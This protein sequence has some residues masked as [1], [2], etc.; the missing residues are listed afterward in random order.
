[1][2]FSR[3]IPCDV[4]DK[5]LTKSKAVECLHH[6]TGKGIDIYG[7]PLEHYCVKCASAK[8]EQLRCLLAD[9]DRER[10]AILEFYKGK[11]SDED[12]YGPL[13]RCPQYVSRGANTSNTYF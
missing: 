10:L 4:C 12:I 5:P 1:M 7:G 13:K 8:I 6:V 11:L 2:T 3:K 9:S